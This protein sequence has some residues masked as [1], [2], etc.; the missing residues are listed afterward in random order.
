[1]RTKTVQDPGASY[2]ELKSRE[3]VWVKSGPDNMYLLGVSLGKLVGTFQKR[4]LFTCWVW[5]G[6]MGGYFL[7]VLTIYLLGMS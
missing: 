2:R 4:P 1:M 5:A 3:S 6:Q 7:K